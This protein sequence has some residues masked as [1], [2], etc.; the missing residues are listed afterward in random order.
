MAHDAANDPLTDAL[1]RAFAAM[2]ETGTVDVVPSDDAV[3]V[4]V[5][6]LADDWTLCVTGW[7]PA[8]AWIALDAA[9][10]SLAEQREQLGRALGMR[11]LAALRAL[12]SETDGALVDRLAHGGDPLSATLAGLITDD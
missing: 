2:V 10:S 12:D 3:E 1:R 8:I 6:V 11:G 9:G 4:E 7:P 5:E